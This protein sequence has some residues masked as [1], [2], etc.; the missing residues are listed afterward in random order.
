MNKAVTTSALIISSLLAP[1]VFSQDK[2]SAIVPFFFSTETMG[3][4]Y[5]L[6]GVA[7]GVGQPQ[8]ALFGMGLY[9][10]K[11]SYLT[12]LSAYNYA[13]SSE[14]LFTAQM[15]QAHFNEMPYYLGSQGKNDSRYEDKTVTNSDEEHYQ[16][17]FK[18]LLPWGTFKNEGLNGVFK[19]RRNVTTA[20]PLESGVSSISFTPFYS[21]RKLDAR[22]REGELATGFKLTFDWDNRDSVR[23]SSRGSHTALDITL[24][25]RNWGFSDPWVKWEFQNSHYFALGPLGDLFD[26][27]IL[28]F[29]IYTADTPTWNQCN[30]NQCARP[31]EQEQVSLGGLYRLRGSTSGRYHGRSAIHY[32]ME[33]RVMP[34]WQPLNDIPVINYYN[35]PWWQWVVFLE[36]GRVADEYNL[37]TLHQDMQWNIGAAVRFQVEGIV[38][39]AEIAEGSDEGM[40]RVMINQPF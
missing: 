40:F 20:S 11:D 39:R 8:A 1:K 7:K 28:A 9:S 2:D 32:S 29:D 35:M 10:S 22:D 16:A 19:P 34:E 21:L 18:Y 14:L 31:P 24:G 15:Y 27:Q 25:D 37:E 36:S 26:Q 5:G 17:E 23:N 3:A 4:T 38:V 6:A 33:Y 30:G 13:L 12:F